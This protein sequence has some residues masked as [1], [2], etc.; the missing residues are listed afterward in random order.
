MPTAVVLASDISWSQICTFWDGWNNT[1]GEVLPCRLEMTHAYVL[2]KFSE[3]WGELIA[4]E[5]EDDGTEVPAGPYTQ[6]RKAGYPGLQEMLVEHPSLLS[7]LIL[8]SLQTE[9]AGFL[10]CA[11]HEV[12]KAHPA[13]FLQS[14]KS[15]EINSTTVVLTGG[16]CAI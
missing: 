10:L 8:S 6:L 16:C 14:L 12:N 1:E 3:Y 7:S 5:S 15:I 13:Y 2:K 9:F 11:P 4:R